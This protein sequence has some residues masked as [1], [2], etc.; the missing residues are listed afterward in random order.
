MEVFLR[1]KTFWPKF[2]HQEHIHT[3]MLIVVDEMTIL[4]P[5]STA[6]N[7]AIVIKALQEY[8][9]RRLV[10]SD[11]K[12]LSLVHCRPY[13]MEV[14]SAAKRLARM[15]AQSISAKRLASR[16]LPYDKLLVAYIM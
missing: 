6:A 16:S 9:S 10:G 11:E 7:V 13:H 4:C 1:Q 5:A 3:D 15:F 8:Y 14:F 12:V 2:R